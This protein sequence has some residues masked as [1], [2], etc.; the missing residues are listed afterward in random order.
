MDMDCETKSESN[1]EKKN[2]RKT[3][4]RIQKKRRSKPHSQIS[5]PSLQRRQQ[6]KSSKK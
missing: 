6:R 1:I 5:F 2:P 4:S 3:P